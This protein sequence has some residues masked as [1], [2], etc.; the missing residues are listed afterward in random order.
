ML[1]HKHHRERKKERWKE[2]REEKKRREDRK[3]GFSKDC[4]SQF[5]LIPK[6]PSLNEYNHF[7]FQN[8]EAILGLIFHKFFLEI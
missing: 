7:H 3:G 4:P 6:S 1:V 5:H 8:S 2:R